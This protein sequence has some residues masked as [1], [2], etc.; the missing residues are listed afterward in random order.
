MVHHNAWVYLINWLGLDLVGTLEAKP[1]IPPTSAHL[2]Q[3]LEQLQQ[4]PARVIVRSPYQSPRAS[5]WLAERTGIPAIVLPSTV[6]GNEAAQD[7]FGL[8]NNIV[9][10][11]LG[12]AS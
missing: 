2:S 8:F 11:L 12:E 10:Q 3:L 5:E 9:Q 7:L 6:G 4:Q 1:G